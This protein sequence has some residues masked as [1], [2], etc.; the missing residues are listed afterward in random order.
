EYL[1]SGFQYLPS[2]QYKWLIRRYK[3]GKEINPLFNPFLSNLYYFPCNLRCRHTLNRLKVMAKHIITEEK[4]RHLLLPII[5]FLPDTLGASS[6]RGS[7]GNMEYILIE[8]ISE[9]Y[10]YIRYRALPATRQTS[11]TEV[12]S[13]GN[14]LS[15]SEG[16]MTIFNNDKIIHRFCLNACIW[17]YKKTYDAGFW[18]LFIRLLLNAIQY[19]PVTIRKFIEDNDFIKIKQTLNNKRT[20]LKKYNLDFRNISS[21]LNEI[22]IELNFKNR[23]NNTLT[24]SVQKSSYAR[25]FFIRGKN[26]SISIKEKKCNDNLIYPVSVL[27]LNLIENE[28]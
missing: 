4:N 1:K 3:A 13:K 14:S 15:L 21:G 10:N 11:N 19:K 5:F 28:T 22:L 20:I 2:F 24:L 18:K 23:D 26:Y 9:K 16:V 6:T 17:Y 8:P 7:A 12:I 27:L 25:N